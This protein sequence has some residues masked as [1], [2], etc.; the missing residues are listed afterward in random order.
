MLDKHERWSLHGER[1]VLLLEHSGDLPQEVCGWPANISWWWN[2]LFGV[3]LPS[4]LVMVTLSIWRDSARL[5][6]RSL[7]GL[8]AGYGYT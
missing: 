5:A 4:A 8:G 6:E 1:K 7:R 3:A 2:L